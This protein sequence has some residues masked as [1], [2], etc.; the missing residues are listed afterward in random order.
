MFLANGETEQQLIE[1]EIKHTFYVW[2]VGMFDSC[3]FLS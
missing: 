3:V 2:Y 1:T